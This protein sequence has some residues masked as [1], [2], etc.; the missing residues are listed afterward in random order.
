[1]HCST[2]VISAADKVDRLEAGTALPPPEAAEL[3]A[4]QAAAVA[5]AAPVALREVAEEAE[6][7]PD[8]QQEAV[9]AAALVALRGAAEEVEAEPDAQQAAAEEGSVAQQQA[10]EVVPNAQ[11][12]A[13]KSDAQQEALAGPQDAQRQEEIP[14]AQSGAR[15]PEP[16]VE[17]AET[18]AVRLWCRATSFLALA[19]A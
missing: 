2:V 1:L 10:V 9:A 14:A 18:A 15:Q 3:D 5:A 6:A 7:E 13:A 19:P 4:Q 8:A 16:W 17:S 12:E 11:L